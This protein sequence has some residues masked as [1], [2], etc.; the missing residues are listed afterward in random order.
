M[1]WSG[2]M[3]GR[4]K[5][6][7]GGE[8]YIFQVNPRESNVPSFSRKLIALTT[9]N[10]ATIVAEGNPEP[11][12]FQFNGVLLDATQFDALAK[13]AGDSAYSRPVFLTD[14]YKRQWTVMVRSFEPTMQPTRA[15]YPYRHTWNMTCV[16]ISGPV[17]L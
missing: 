13:W 15:L 8:S 4:W 2:Q 3:I 9:T 14:H 12:V 1:P 5:L 17:Y 11:P 16:V 7:T 10:G 6:A